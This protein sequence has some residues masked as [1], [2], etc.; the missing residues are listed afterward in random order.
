MAHEYL[1]TE[2]GEVKAKAEKIGNDIIIHV[3]SMDKIIAAQKVVKKVKA[4]KQ[5]KDGKRSVL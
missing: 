2:D 4:E 3:P 1:M 5:K